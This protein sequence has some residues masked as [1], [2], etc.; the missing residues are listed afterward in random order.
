MDSN[1]SNLK[2]ENGRQ[3]TSHSGSFNIIE[4]GKGELSVIGNMR[5]KGIFGGK[6]NVT[7]TLIIDINGKFTGELKATD[8][9]VHGQLVGTI[10]ISDTTTFHGTSRFSGSLTAMHIDISE[11]SVINGR[12]IADRIIQ[13]GESKNQIA[14]NLD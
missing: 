9:I 7:G 13:K 12:R 5:I 8:L 3:H 10:T 4:A 11:G 1:G 6:L 2:K 14:L